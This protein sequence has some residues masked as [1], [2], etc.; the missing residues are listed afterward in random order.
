MKSRRSRRK[1]LTARIFKHF[2]DSIS[3]LTLAHAQ[4][5][6]G[7]RRVAWVIESL[8]HVESDWKRSNENVAILINREVVDAVSG[9]DLLNML[10]AVVF[11]D[12]VDMNSTCTYAW[13][14]EKSIATESEAVGKL[15]LVG[16]LSAASRCGANIDVACLED[17]PQL[18]L[19]RIETSVLP[20][21]LC[22]Q[23]KKKERNTYDSNLVLSVVVREVKQVS[24]ES[25]HAV[26]RR[27]GIIGVGA[28][29]LHRSGA[30]AS[31]KDLDCGI[32]SNLTWAD[33]RFSRTRINGRAV[34][35]S[36]QCDCFLALLSR[37]EAG[38][39][40]KV[41]QAVSS[42]AGVSLSPENANAGRVEVW[43]IK[44]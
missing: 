2:V 14:V 7:W 11:E 21:A 30:G 12:P 41:Q 28:D 18:V 37:L 38:K 9:F 31:L 13:D 26:G 15:K 16:D 1:Y 3:L 33:I 40:N 10:D 24:S 19:L 17:E 4:Y 25:G 22:L 6:G 44:I 35:H 43:K 42:G 32:G 34:I 5:S 20:L 27:D 29:V 39:T 36:E 23:K 8:H